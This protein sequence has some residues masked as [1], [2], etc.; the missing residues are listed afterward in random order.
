MSVRAKVIKCDTNDQR[1]WL[2]VSHKLNQDGYFRKGWGGSKRYLFHRI[3]FQHFNGDIPEGFDIDHKCKNRSCCNPEHLRLFKYGPHQ[4]ET[5]KARYKHVIDSARLHWLD[6]PN[7][8]GT[9][10]GILHDRTPSWGCI[11]IK[12]FKK[13][14]NRT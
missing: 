8:T 1:C 5:N 11:S 7:I 12:K 6:N 3:M 9:E 2:V 13:E 10:L 14:F 4:A